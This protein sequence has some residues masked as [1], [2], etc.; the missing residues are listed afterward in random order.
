MHYQPFYS[1]ITDTI[2]VGSLPLPSDVQY[3]HEN[4]VIGVINMCWEYAGPLKEYQKFKIQQLHL[5]TLDLSEPRLADMFLAVQFLQ[6]MKEENPT[7]RVFIHC[8]GDIRRQTTTIFS[9]IFQQIDYFY[10]PPPHI[11]TFFLM[12][13]VLLNIFVGGRGR[14]VTTAVCCLVALNKSTP[15][16]AFTIIK[17]R[18]KVS[19][20]VVVQSDVVRNF[21]S[22][23][24]GTSSSKISS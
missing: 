11:S 6:K 1:E 15:E 9:V 2:S 13:N 4:D 24:L 8:K 19:A 5:P 20:G 18:R 12:L 16:D 23:V 21:S 3:L 14:A 7:G 22:S 17:S 10:F